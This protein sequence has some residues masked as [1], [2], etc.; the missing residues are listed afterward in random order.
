[1][2]PAASCT[3][4]SAGLDPATQGGGEYDSLGVQVASVKLGDNQL[5]QRPADYNRAWEKLPA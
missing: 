4:L 1:M 2:K 5:F 3:R